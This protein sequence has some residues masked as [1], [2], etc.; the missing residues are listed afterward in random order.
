MEA[1]KIRWSGGADLEAQILG[2]CQEVMGLED[3]GRVRSNDAEPIE[4]GRDAAA[5]LKSSAD[6]Q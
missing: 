1:L 4:G 2:L 3:A 6:F 5:V